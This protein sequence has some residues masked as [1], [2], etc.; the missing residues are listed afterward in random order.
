M[1]DE[2]RRT[3]QYVWTE[4]AEH[5]EAGGLFQQPAAARLVE[6]VQLQGAREWTSGG[7]RVSTLERGCRAQRSRWAFS[8]AYP[9][10]FKKAQ[11]RGARRPTS[12]GVL[13]SYVEASRASATK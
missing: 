1:A 13:W 8:A 11:V 7:V 10:A 3:C 2:R 4:A 5:N 12:R 6:K 9:Q